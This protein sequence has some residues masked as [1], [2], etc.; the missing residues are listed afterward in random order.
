MDIKDPFCLMDIRQ[1]A[2]YNLNNM[3]QI[4]EDLK[5]CFLVVDNTPEIFCFKDYD[6]I[7]NVTCVSYV[8]QR[9]AKQKLNKIIAG[10]R[11]SGNSGKNVTCWNIYLENTVEFTVKGLKFFSQDPHVFSYF[12]GY[13]YQ[14]VDEVDM[15]KIQPF[16]SHVHDI[17]CSG[18]EELYKYVLDW[19]ASILQRPSFKT[20]TALL[21][22]GKQGS[23]KNKFF[24]D[25]LCRLMVPYC[26]ENLTNLDD[27]IGKFNAAMEN[28]KLIVCNELQSIDVN[29][30]LNSDALK[31]VITDKQMNINQ[32]NQP[33][34]L[35]ENV[36]NLILVSNNMAPV[37]IEN[38]DRRYVVL[39]TSD[40]KC[41]DFEY[42]DNLAQTFD[43]EFYQHLF[44]YFMT[45]DVTMVNLRKIPHTQAKE[46]IMEASKNSVELYVDDNWR[47]VE[48]KT[49]PVLY[50]HY[51]AYCE[52]F[53]YQPMANRTF[54]AHLKSLTG[55]SK[56]VYIEGKKTRVYSLLPSVV[57]RYQKR[58][59]EIL[60][61][62][63]EQAELLKE[64][65][66]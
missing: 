18:N 6:A 66:E 42:F 63:E 54:V 16:L 12:R 34:R 60:E 64:L 48:K 24:T 3:N 56:L 7:N 53:G 47:F 13:D 45:Y 40:A 9:E 10:V 29:K 35:Q 8:G 55:E 65:T 50:D 19:Y 15:E 51:R 30:F 43:E 21:I 32:K 1:N 46:D 28:K 5:K 11:M 27:I 36:V 38:G 26:N 25:I 17:I 59:K 57:E 39:R 20:E 44:T 41:K 4:I 49:G 52:R 2:P 33:V 14:L 58:D 61:A 62:E 22:V 23:G 37:K 31:S